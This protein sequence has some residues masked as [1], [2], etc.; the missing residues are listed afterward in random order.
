M[1]CRLAWA[2][3]MA[4]AVMHVLRTRGHTSNGG[5]ADPNLN[6]QEGV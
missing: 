3:T 1:M 4:M 6:I 5:K 2:G